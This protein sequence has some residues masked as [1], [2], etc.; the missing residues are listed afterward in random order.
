MNLEEK[1]TKVVE[2]CLDEMYQHSKPPISWK[3]ILKKYGG[4]KHSEFYL[5]HVISEEDY[6]KIKAK[7]QK[8]L[9]KMYHR[10]LDM[11]LLNYAPTFE[12]EKQKKK[13]LGDKKQ[14]K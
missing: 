6:N 9:H 3:E 11:E 14:I 1:A 8:K 10:S 4:K 2:E 5:K 7:H 12:K 13:K